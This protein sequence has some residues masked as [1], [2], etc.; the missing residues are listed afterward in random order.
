VQALTPQCWA[1]ALDSRRQNNWRHSVGLRCRTRDT[2]RTRKQRHTQPPACQ[3]T[4]PAPTNADRDGRS[5]SLNLACRH[6]HLRSFSPSVR[7]A[8]ASR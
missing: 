7:W 3:C 6:L 4:E 2:H 5:N 1:F 8:T